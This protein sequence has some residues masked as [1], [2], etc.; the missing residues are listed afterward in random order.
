MDKIE[1]RWQS[2]KAIREALVRENILMG[3]MTEKQAAAAVAKKLPIYEMVLFGQ[4]LS[5]FSKM[6][7]ADVAKGAFIEGRQTK[8]KAV[9]LQAKVQRANGR[10]LDVLFAF[11][12]TVG[13]KPVIGPGERQL[14]VQVTAN[15]MKIKANFNTQ[16]MVNKAGLLDL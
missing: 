6:S 3:K 10:V 11:P 8:V 12:K 13:G 2:A 15:K 4:D 1:V 16:K 5:Q 14:N 7:D 9:A